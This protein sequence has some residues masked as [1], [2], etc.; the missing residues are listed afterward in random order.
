MIK[1]DINFQYCLS[2][3]SELYVAV[4][5]KATRLH[6]PANRIINKAIKEYLER[7][8]SEAEREEVVQ[9]HSDEA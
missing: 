8:P 9:Y 4:K 2:I 3:P 1:K 6:V 5:K 7:N